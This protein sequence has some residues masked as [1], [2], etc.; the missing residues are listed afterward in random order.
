MEFFLGKHNYYKK[1]SDIHEFNLSTSYI[2]VCPLESLVMSSFVIMTT[3]DNLQMIWTQAC[4]R[5]ISECFEWNV[6]PFLFLKPVIYTYST[7]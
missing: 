4:I 1:K 7:M 3:R 2:L 5:D 6:E